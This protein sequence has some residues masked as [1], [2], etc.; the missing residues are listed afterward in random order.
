MRPATW[1]RPLTRK[2]VVVLL[3]YGVLYLF[4]VAYYRF[5]SLRDPGSFFFDP[6]EG[7][8]PRYSIQRI[9][10]A[11]QF[12]AQFNHSSVAH[13]ENATRHKS[14]TTGVTLCIGIVTVRR[15][16]M[17]NLDVTVGSVFDGLTAEQR[18]AISLSVLFAHSDPTF[19][20]DY[21]QSWVAELADRVLTYTELGVPASTVVRL[22]A[23]RKIEEKSLL[24]YRL[25]LQSCYRNTDAPWFLMLEDDVVAERDWYEHTLTASRQLV[26][27]QSRRAGGL[28][29]WLYLRLF[30]TEKFLGWN[31]EEWSVYSV[32]CLAAVALPAVVGVYLRRRVQSLQGVLTNAFLAL[33]CLVCVPLAIVLYFLAGRVTVQP[34]R[35][36]IHKMNRSGCCSQALLFPRHQVPRL[37][38]H[39]E[40]LQAQWP[41]AVD[42]AI[43]ELADQDGLDRFVLA[44]SRF[45]HVGAAS[46]KESRSSFVWEGPHPVRG[47]HG[48]WSMSFE[49][50]YT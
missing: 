4:A 13:H 35:A 16:M 19:H 29:R 40:T 44:P 43:E 10:E 27:E 28:Q 42:S 36:G 49:D 33:V 23:G 45:Q 12:V 1:R 30:Y 9:R 3:T 20:P 7:Y 50:A 18:S 14:Y 34:L 11:S 32:W 48:V 8:R 25:S 6:N 37:I 22:E 17:Q 24:D 26:A 39:L 46:Y 31:S 21:G 5:H 15:P 2:Q 38:D 41:M 47:A